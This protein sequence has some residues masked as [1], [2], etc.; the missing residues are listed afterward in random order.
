MSYRVLLT[1]GGSGGHV[2][3]LVAV[4]EALQKNAKGHGIKL[5]IM[6]MG[7]GDFIESVARENNFRFRRV[8]SGK[9]RRYFSFKNI[10]DLFKFPIGFVQAMWHV[11]WFMPD[12]I[13][14][15]G[16]YASV[17]PAL[18]GRIY[19]IPLFLHETD[20]IPGLANR[21]LAKRAKKIFIS[22]NKSADY[23][24]KS[25]IIFTG[26]P[27]RSGLFGESKE[28]AMSYFK[29]NPALPTLLILGGSQGAQTLNNAILDGLVRLTEKFQIIH[30]C[31][32]AN[33][34]T[35]KSDIEKIISEGAGLYGQIVSDRIK[36]F[37]F[38]NSQDLRMAY[39]ACDVIVTRA[40]GAL[41]EVAMAG[42][43]AIVIPIAESSNN[44]QILNAIEFSQF[45]AV[46]IEEN[47]L[48]E[49]MLMG[50]IERI[51]KPENYGVLSE[52]IKKFAQPEASNIIARTLLKIK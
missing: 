46:I 30:Q 22:F 37:P 50:D 26:N 21:I 42:K 6:V 41:F 19:L 10:A 48:T 13:F 32:D 5:E 14:A 44:H 16:G 39:S 11:F 29:L 17:L 36:V 20:S 33:L 34:P 15:K 27:V 3:P 12:A 8:V 9:L 49:S 24:N 40:G 51:L 1:G 38:L 7:D 23:L 45:G 25:K 31:G 52:N 43:P 4:A 28:V 47:N 35:F 18:A 2:Y